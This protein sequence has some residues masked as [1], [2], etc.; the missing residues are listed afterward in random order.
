ML[1]VRPLSTRAGNFREALKIL[2][3]LS[4]RRTPGPSALHLSVRKTLPPPAF[5]GATMEAEAP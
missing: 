4:S 5:A 2:S 3:H 1:L